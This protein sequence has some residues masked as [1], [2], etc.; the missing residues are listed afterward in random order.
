M[1]VSAVQA[2]QVRPSTRQLAWQEL[3]FYAFIHFSMN[4]FTDR[5]WGDGTEAPSLFDPSALDARQWARA[6]KSAG[7]KGLILTCK[8]HD[9]FCL[10]PSACT[11]HSV[12]RSPWRDGGGDLVREVADA[13]REEGLQFGV[14]LS[15][16]DRH[17]ASYGDSPAYNAYF[18]NQLRELLT[19]YGE[20][21]CVWFD[22]A[23]GEGPNGK[24]QVYD[25]DAY[26]AL[27]REL[28]PG[29]VI[30]VCGPDVRWCGNEAGHTRPSEWSVVPASMRDNEK[31]Q[32][33]SQQEDDGGAFATRVNT[34][35]DDLGSRAVLALADE[36][37]WYPA[38]VNTSIRPGWFY[39]AAEDDRVLTLA[40]LADLYERTVGGNAS[41]LLN[42]PP[43]RRG[44]VH[45]RDAAHLAELGAWLAAAYGDDLAAGAIATASA[46]S[47]PEHGASRAADGRTDTYWCP[48][49]GTEQAALEIDLGADRSFDRI[50]L[51]E[52]IR[53]GQRVE[54]FRLDAWR[55]GGWQPL[56]EGTVIGA[57]RICRVAATSARK[58]RLLIDESRYQPTISA[59][60]VY[61]A[62]EAALFSM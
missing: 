31:I 6:V 45:E 51:R 27:I 46:E 21:F 14:Y 56:A 50:V 54:R 15:P 53:E 32:A 58:L 37:V 13:C 17:E 24:R 4:T 39:H 12:R 16:W 48:P 18:L 8:H 34:E 11:E 42:I 19:G 30:S 36:A 22:G 41:F 35:D 20:V 49:E 61:K 28:Q 60:E 62:G 59:F 43:D 44:L 29:A 26:Y 1:P 38:E 40:Q 52:Q 5:E 47:D 2:A 55:E 33:K 10:W 9:G 23:C 25:W 7:M 3:E 57:K